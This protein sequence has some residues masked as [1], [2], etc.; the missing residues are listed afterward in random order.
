MF[1]FNCKVID[2]ESQGPAAIDLSKGG[3][4]SNMDDLKKVV[5]EVCNTPV[6]VLDSDSVYHLFNV[7]ASHS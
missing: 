2:D 5:C 3:S 4:S 6:G 7:L 1:T